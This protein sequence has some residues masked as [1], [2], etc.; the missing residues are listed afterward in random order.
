MVLGKNR[1]LQEEIVLEGFLELKDK[2]LFKD[3]VEPVSG[4]AFEPGAMTAFF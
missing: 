4:A 1:L 2:F 3:V